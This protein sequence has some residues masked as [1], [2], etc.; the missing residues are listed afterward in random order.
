MKELWQ[1]QMQLMNE[2]THKLEIQ[3]QA[4]EQ[5][6]FDAYIGVDF[7]KSLEAIKFHNECKVDANTMIR[8]KL[9]AKAYHEE[10]NRTLPDSTER[11]LGWW[12]ADLMPEIKRDY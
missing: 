2:I 11:L 6:V 3:G 10:H 12:A 9:L 4:M 7:L 8:L 1:Q 5:K